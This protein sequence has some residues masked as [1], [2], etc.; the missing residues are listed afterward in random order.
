M[1]LYRIYTEDKNSGL[2]R[3]ILDKVLPAYTVLNGQGV[4]RSIPE[5]GLVI[6]YMGQRNDR[7]I[8]ERLCLEIKQLNQQECVI[9]TESEVKLFTV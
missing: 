5:S 9:F 1:I 3:K 4:W 7:V 8:V 6:E 2:I